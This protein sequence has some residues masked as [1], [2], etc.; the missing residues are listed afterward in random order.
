MTKAIMFLMK[1]IHV[2]NGPAYPMVGLF[3]IVAKMEDQLKALGYRE[4]K[5]KKTVFSD[6]PAPG[7][8]DTNSITL[9]FKIW[10]NCVNASTP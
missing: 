4:I 1:E 10:R 7:L 6:R 2:P 8:E 9:R 3:P 5:T